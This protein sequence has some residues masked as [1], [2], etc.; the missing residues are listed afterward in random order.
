MIWLFL[1]MHRNERFPTEYLQK[2]EALFEVLMP[3]VFSKYKDM[4]VET[5]ELNKSLAN[6]LKVTLV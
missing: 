1:Q 2:I 6:F 4:V 5:M 3:Y